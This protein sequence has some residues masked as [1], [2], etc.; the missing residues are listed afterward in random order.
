MC[1]LML[2][3][4]HN[5]RGFVV[6]MKNLTAMKKII[7]LLSAV[8]LTLSVSAQKVDPHKHFPGKVFTKRT[9]GES[10]L[11]KKY[12]KYLPLK[13]KSSEEI[14]FKN[15]NTVKQQLDMVYSEGQDKDEFRYDS[16][17]KLIED[18]YYEWNANQWE[19]IE[20]YEYTYD[21]KGSL[22]LET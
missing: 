17:G 1:M 3:A 13:Q 21:E 18:I 6:S 9:S 7:T 4:E 8:L 20:K 16:K 12:Y 15:T 2:R 10:I 19:R 22:T 14:H 11:I 5:V